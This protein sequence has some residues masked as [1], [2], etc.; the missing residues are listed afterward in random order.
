[1]SWTIP[2]CSIAASALFS[3]TAHAG[4][5]VSLDQ[6][7][8]QATLT[9]EI[10]TS[11]DRAGSPISSAPD[12]SYG[13]TDDVTLSIVHSTFAMTGFRGAAGGGVCIADCAHRYDNVGAEGLYGF[14]RGPLAAGVVGGVL[15]TSIDRGFA[16]LK[17]GGKLRATSGRIVIASSPSVFVALSH[18]DD[19]MPNRDRLWLPVS[20][21]YKVAPPFSVGVA[22]GF[23]APLDD[24]SGGYE[25][26]AGVVAQYTIASD[27][28]AGASWIQGRIL[29][30][31]V[32]LPEGASGWDARAL[33]IWLSLT[34]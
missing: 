14:A 34:R 24:V 21:S 28:S 33:Q 15:V 4:P 20:A 25:I 1:M 10:N 16:A 9:T 7:R 2:T 19:A 12:V 26:A 23:K 27:L 6:G 5:G 22:G 32:A 3:I 29:G 11:E 17:F 8:V 18:R 30:G 13:V 31:D